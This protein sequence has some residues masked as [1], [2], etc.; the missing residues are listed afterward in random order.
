M[1]IKIT[2][3]CDQSWS[4]MADLG[5]GRHCAACDSPVLDLTN[6]SDHELLS[7]LQTSGDL[8]CC[9]F[10]NSQLER[11]L[12]K[13]TGTRTL[14]ALAFSTLLSLLSSCESDH[15]STVSGSVSLVVA[16][17]ADQTPGPISS[18]PVVKCNAP[19]Q[20]H[21]R[22]VDAG[23]RVPIG[24]GWIHVLRSGWPDYASLDIAESTPDGRFVLELCPTSDRVEIA[25]YGA[26]FQFEMNAAQIGD[27]SSSQPIPTLY[28]PMIQTIHI[29]GLDSTRTHSINLGDIDLQ[30]KTD[31]SMGRPHIER[32]REWRSI[33]F[34]KR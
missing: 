8:P 11:T 33:F 19:V 21:G 25:F 26:E 3:P 27:H 6:K 4:N 14:P 16:D 12:G 32:R 2:N 28:E 31:F 13:D 23:S 20:V 5:T 9:R 34:I 30:E 22:L 1:R 18:E 15:P 7:I 29:Q 10:K 17:K 24:A